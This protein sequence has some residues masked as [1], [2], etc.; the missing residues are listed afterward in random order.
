MLDVACENKVSLS[1]D[2]SMERRLK[3]TEAI[4]T[5][6]L[7]PA[8]TLPGT[9]TSR[10]QLWLETRAKRKCGPARFPP[11]PPNITSVACCFVYRQTLPDGGSV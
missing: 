11:D 9:T 2:S 8:E 10:Q 1:G 7:Q 3:V 4:I 5:G 6:C